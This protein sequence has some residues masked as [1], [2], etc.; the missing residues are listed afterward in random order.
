MNLTYIYEDTQG[1]VYPS[2]ILN[3]SAQQS[4]CSIPRNYSL[5]ILQNYLSISPEVETSSLKLR[6][7]VN[8][9]DLGSNKQG[10]GSQFREVGRTLRLRQGNH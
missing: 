5:T 2:H 7:N 3:M 6:K 10:A 9:E 8:Q 1:L 4:A